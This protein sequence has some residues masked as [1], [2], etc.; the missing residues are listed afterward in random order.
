MLGNGHAGFGEAARE[1]PTNGNIGRALRVDL[2]APSAKS[3]PRP[4]SRSLADSSMSSGL[5]Y[6]TTEPGN[7][8]RQAPH[9]PLDKIIEIQLWHI[10]KA[11]RMS[12]HDLQARPIYH[13][14]RESID[15]HLTSCSPP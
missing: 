4:R 15:A 11:F 1:Q 7:H 14:L 12:K 13:H 6:A 8:S 2:T 10:E 3:T 5:S 9:R